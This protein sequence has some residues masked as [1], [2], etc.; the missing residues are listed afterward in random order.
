MNIVETLGLFGKEKRLLPY[1]LLVV[2]WLLLQAFLF[3]YTFI[4]I[5]SSKDPFPLRRLLGF[6]L[7]LA[8]ASAALCNLNSALII[9]SMCRVT[10]DLLYSVPILSRFPWDQ[11]KYFH[12]LTSYS[13]LLFSFIHIVSHYINMAQLS[14]S[15]L[16]V[17]VG[18]LLFLSGVGISGHVL[19]LS[20]LGISITSIL[21][22]VRK[23]WYEIFWISHQALI[24]V[25]T[26]SLS[27]HGAFC[28][29]KLNSSGEV[30]KCSV[31]S[32]WRWLVGPL[33]ILSVE[34]LYRFIRV[35]RRTDVL[36]V[37]AHPSMVLELHI[38]KPSMRF[39]PGQYVYINIPAIS[40]LQW[41]PFTI[42]SVPEEGFIGIHIRVCGKWTKQVANKCGIDFLKDG[43]IECLPTNG[44]P[45]VFVDG[46][47]GDICRNVADY[48]C[49][50][51]I[52]AGIGQTPFAAILK[53]LR[54]RKSGLIIDMG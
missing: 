35:M 20:L 48:E 8:K 26:V 15:I 49:V 17:N 30:I 23:K 3:T 41:H 39:K 53:S 40:K 24:T 37:I 4:K 22:Q 6:W 29:V 32:S 12:K 25:Y 42:T 45:R 51:L 44:L 13:L 7:A 9:L 11:M 54:Y 33:A 38:R 47:F 50:V 16:N 19:I 43:T 52:G 31:A 36:R 28:F 2:L 46:P 5:E 1:C 10:I 27:L 18:K 14:G 21:K 34:K